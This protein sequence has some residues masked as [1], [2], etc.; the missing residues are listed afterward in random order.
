MFYKG[1]R[2]NDFVEPLQDLLGKM[3]HRRQEFQKND[4]QKKIQ[5]LQKKFDND[6]VQFDND[7][8]AGKNK[9]QYC[10]IFWD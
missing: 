9:K 6:F 4:I 3:K 2:E 5:E 8:E 7:P 10:C 1:R